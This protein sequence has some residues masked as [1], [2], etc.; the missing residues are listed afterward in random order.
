LHCRRFAVDPGRTSPR[1]SWGPL[2][3]HDAGPRFRYTSRD[4]NRQSQQHSKLPRLHAKPPRAVDAHVMELKPRL[5]RHHGGENI[6]PVAVRRDR[7][8]PQPQGSQAVARLRTGR[9]W[10]GASLG[11]RRVAHPPYWLI[12]LRG[13]GFSEQGWSP[14]HARADR[15]WAA[16][17]VLPEGD[18]EAAAS[19]Q[20]SSSW[21]P[22]AG[23]ASTNRA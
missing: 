12:D 19:S 14:A 17:R 8:K 5:P 23:L 13:T 21:T 20:G 16:K 15:C 9:N 7:G 10:I 6:T 2:V 3:V 18:T 4:E 22:G 1:H 11:Y